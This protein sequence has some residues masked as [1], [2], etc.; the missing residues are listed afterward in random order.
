MKLLKDIYPEIEIDDIVIRPTDDDV[1]INN[2]EYRL[3]NVYRKIWSLKE[4]NRFGNFSYWMVYPRI[5]EEDTIQIDDLIFVD[6]EFAKH[7]VSWTYAIR[8]QDEIIDGKMKR[9]SVYIIF[10][11][12]K[13]FFVEKTSSP[14]GPTEIIRYINNHP[15]NFNQID[16]WTKFVG[17]NVLYYGHSGIVTRFNPHSHYIEITIHG[18]DRFMNMNNSRSDYDALGLLDTKMC[19][20][21]FDIAGDDIIARASILNPFIQW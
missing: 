7:P 13:E 3:A 5:L 2:C 6:D 11:N 21:T 8:D 14:F 20:Q 15:F 18:R 12:N 16:Y 17:R 4:N 9:S 10:R 1:V 19:Y